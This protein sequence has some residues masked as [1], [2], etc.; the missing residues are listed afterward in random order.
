MLRTAVLNYRTWDAG[1]VLLRNRA[2]YVCKSTSAKDKYF[3]PLD[4]GRPVDRMHPPSPNGSLNQSTPSPSRSESEAGSRTMMH[5][6]SS[7]LGT[8]LGR[9]LVA[10]AAQSQPTNGTSQTL[11][12]RK[13]A[14]PA[15]PWDRVRGASM[16]AYMDKRENESDDDKESLDL[17]EVRERLHSRVAKYRQRF[18]D[19][20]LLDAL[21]TSAYIEAI[22][23]IRIPEVNAAAVKV[24]AAHRGKQGRKATAV[25]RQ[26]MAHKK[27]EQEKAATKVQSLYRGKQGRQTVHQLRNDHTVV[28]QPSPKVDEGDRTD[29]DYEDDDDFEADDFE[30]DFEADDGG[31]GSA[32]GDEETAAGTDAASAA[33]EGPEPASPAPS[34]PRRPSRAELDKP[35]PPEPLDTAASAEQAAQLNLPG[36]YAAATRSAEDLSDAARQHTEAVARNAPERAIAIAE[37]L[38]AIYARV[39]ARAA[40]R[41][42]PEGEGNDSAAT[43]F[44][45]LT[46][47][48]GLLAAAQG[49]G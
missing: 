9:K 21:L 14:N 7:R 41:A 18:N 26:R 12:Q 28:G 1:S 6:Q 23:A 49:D 16:A 4:G 8:S 39:L 31:D 37:N 38:Q 3:N 42:A 2:V 30:D 32:Q 11:L 48:A 47:R 43:S 20:R 13:L 22:E 35:L 33:D 29:P 15:S 24:Q 17:N 36:V 27:L 19:Q 34:A 46:F 25:E 40:E 45:L 44:V 5:R 10:Q